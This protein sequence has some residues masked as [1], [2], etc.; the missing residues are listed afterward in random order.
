MAPVEPRHFY[1]MRWSATRFY[2]DC[3]TL[4]ADLVGKRHRTRKDF[5]AAAET[6]IRVIPDGCMRPPEPLSR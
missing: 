4:A 2:A 1:I 5:D 6:M 3:G